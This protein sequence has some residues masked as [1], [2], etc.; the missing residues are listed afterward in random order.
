MCVCVCVCVCVSVC[1]C[2]HTTQNLKSQL[3]RKISDRSDELASKQQALAAAQ[4]EN[5]E[6]RARIA[7]QPV[8]K[9]DLSRMVMER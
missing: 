5:E 7:A 2:V 8:S 9:A 4:R 6:L 1:L 3:Q